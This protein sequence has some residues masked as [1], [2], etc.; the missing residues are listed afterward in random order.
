[1]NLKE[2]HQESIDLVG[3]IWDAMQSVP[4][5]SR[6][7]DVLE[8]AHRMAGGARDCIEDAIRYADKKP[9]LS[10][11]EKRAKAREEADLHETNRK[12]TTGRYNFG[13]RADKRLPYTTEGGE[14]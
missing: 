7:W 8:I 11:K 10:L 9:E 14:V 1:M 2:L 6:A 3:Q 12:T 5:D 13:K 4:S